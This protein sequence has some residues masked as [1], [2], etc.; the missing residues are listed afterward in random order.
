ML[1]DSSRETWRQHLRGPAPLSL[2]IAASVWVMLLLVVLFGDGTGE[3]SL[4]AGLPAPAPPVTRQFNQTLATGSEDLPL[5]D[6]RVVRT[7]A[8]YEPEQIR[9]AIAGA[10]GIAVSWSSG[11]ASFRLGQNLVESVVKTS[12]AEQSLVSSTGPQ[13]HR[14]CRDGAVSFP[15]YT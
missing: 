6:P 5:D 10:Q 14:T 1:E 4:N 8:T 15:T 12:G 9:I 11:N 7:A 13:Y 3:P 2:A